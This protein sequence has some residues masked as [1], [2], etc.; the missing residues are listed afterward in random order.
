MQIFYS[1]DLRPKYPTE[2]TI[3]ILN[4]QRHFLRADCNLRIIHQF[5]LCENLFDYCWF[6]VL[7]MFVNHTLPSGPARLTLCILH[8][9]ISKLRDKYSCLTIFGKS[10]NY[11]IRPFSSA[12]PT[13]STQRIRDRKHGQWYVDDE[14]KSIFPQTSPIDETLAADRQGPLIE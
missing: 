13:P 12:W 9:L 2:A 14:R 10:Q 5:I 8:S 11:F 3:Y 4:L 7:Y 6:I 1:P